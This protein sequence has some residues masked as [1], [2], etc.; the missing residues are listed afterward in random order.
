MKQQKNEFE[1]MTKPW[2]LNRHYWKI[3][4][5]NSITE[6][7][8]NPVLKKVSAVQIIQPLGENETE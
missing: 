5:K 1:T 4:S 2:L 3:K 6:I 7:I 8:K